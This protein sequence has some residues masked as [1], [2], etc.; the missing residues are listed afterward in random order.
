[1]PDQIHL[2]VATL[3]H[4]DGLLL[5]V[6]EMDKGRLVINQPAGHV[7][8]GESFKS[9]ALRETLEETGYIIELEY[10]LGI[11]VLRAA[12]G[13]TYYRVS[14]IASCPE[15]IPC[16]NLDPDIERAFWMKAE[17][18]LDQ[19][20]QRSE[21]VSRDVERFLSGTRYPLEMIDEKP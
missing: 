20:N 15:Q 21:M 18:V 14:F 5:M 3:C 19:A 8:I 11:S 9:A 13:I 10:V 4:R 16:P 12:N 1:M 7:E 17:D 2:T 6:E